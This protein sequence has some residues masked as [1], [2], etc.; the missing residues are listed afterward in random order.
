MRILL[1]THYY[2][3]EIGAPQ[4]R[5]RELVAGLTD[6]GHE[7]AVCAPVPHYPRSRMS[8]LDIRPVPVWRWYDGSSGER[9]LRV[10]Y[11][12][13]SA[14]MVR[15]LCDQSLSSTAQMAAAASMRGDRPDVVISTMPGL[16]SPFSGA[17]AAALLD[18]PHVVEVRDAWPDLIGDSSLVEHAVRGLLPRRVSRLI[19]S[20]AL[21]ALFHRVYRSAD[22]VVTT[23][24]TFAGRLRERGIDRVT[25]IR[26]SART[27][28]HAVHPRAAEAGADLHLL[29]VGT[30]GRSQDLATVVSAV[31]RVPGVRLRV[32]GEGAGLIGLVE[33]ARGDDRIEF[34]PQTVGPALD[35]HWAWA[36]A[37][38]VSLSPIGAFDVTVPSKLYTTMSR[39]VHVL[40][41]LSGEAASIVRSA[42]AGTIS[43][44]GDVDG[45][46]NAITTLRD[47]RSQLDVGH[48]P[49]RW[50][51]EQASPE[52][53]VSA[54]EDL[55][56]AAVR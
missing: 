37:G 44:P 27:A 53:M 39:G 51:E 7:I 36:D 11:L 26:N 24:E 31:L 50:L 42:G 4:R 56:E 2:E 38:V 21:P 16:P 30:V 15:Q 29:Y 9:V 13:S 23:T 52:R 41:L 25:C 40:G 33:A 28:Q 17:A 48:A 46:V 49:Q 1:L 22:A 18:R 20:R 45:L 55:I 6:R 35:E 3:P 54:Y 47:D 14:S 32:V 43:A 12:P 19:E 10:P 34:F 8:D 5:W